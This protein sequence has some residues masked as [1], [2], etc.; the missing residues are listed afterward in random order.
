[1]LELFILFISDII[2][3]FFFLFFF[4]IFLGFLFKVG[5]ASDIYKYEIFFYNK[6]YFF[7]IILG[8]VYLNL[9]IPI[10]FWSAFD[11][12]VFNDYFSYFFFL[13][14]LIA[15]L[16]FL[17]IFIK[18]N[19]DY[20]Y[21]L[22]YLYILMFIIFI[23]GFLFKVYDFMFVYIL[24]ELL[25]L[26]LYILVA[27][28]FSSIK[29][30]EVGVKYFVMAVISSL[31]LLYAF[32]IIYSTFGTLNLMK[33]KIFILL[34]FALID[35][36]II[37]SLLLFFAAFFFKVGVVPFHIWVIEIYSGVSLSTFFFLSI[38]SKY[39]FFIVLFKLFLNF[40][41]FYSFYY[42]YLILFCGLSS[43]CV[44]VLGALIHVDIRKILA[45]GS[46]THSGF[47]IL[48]FL[49][50]NYYTIYA[51]IFYLISYVLL[52]LNFFIIFFFLK[53]YDYN[54]KT[55]YDLM[56]LKYSSKFLTFNLFFLF[57]S[58]AGLPPFL[59]FFIKYFIL[60]NL[61]TFNDSFFFVVLFLLLL[62]ILAIY[63]YLRFGVY[64]FFSEVKVKIFSIK[65]KSLALYFLLWFFLIINIFGI[66]F[67]FYLYKYCQFFLLYSFICFI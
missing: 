10:N 63:I 40:Y 6:I 56:Y 19:I 27:S 47:L 7:L 38:Y 33:L 31:F 41:Y 48:C 59:G 64:L 42:Y 29:V 34:D 39:I 25:S 66:F 55:L 3:I 43:V 53:N 1:M 57:L 58:M 61:N 5:K 32:I 26:C 44:G 17:F 16:L 20:F 22:E 14:F 9:I 51:F 8:L 46:I 18:I 37:I 13:F 50:I 45:Y 36:L 52:M 62:N 60:V 49:N 54:F 12:L 15:F 24:I 4:I 23:T 21:Y 67:I 11:Y 30:S 2:Y 65:R 28:S 35:N